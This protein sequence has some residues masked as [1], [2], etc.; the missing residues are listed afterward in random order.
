MPAGE[1]PQSV[2]LKTGGSPPRPTCPG[3]ERSLRGT[4][5]GERG[6]RDEPP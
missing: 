2:G 4:L 6:D 1:E 3:G 5:L